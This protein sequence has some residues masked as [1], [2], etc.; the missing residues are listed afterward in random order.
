M[1]QLHRLN[2]L[3]SGRYTFEQ[4]HAAAT[5]ITYKVEQLSEPY[6]TRGFEQCIHGIGEPAN[7][8]TTG[9]CSS[10]RDPWWDSCIR[11]WDSYCPRW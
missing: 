6:C 1:P 2:Q 3:A 5:E 4:A 7:W 9:R 10:G 11:Q 8:A